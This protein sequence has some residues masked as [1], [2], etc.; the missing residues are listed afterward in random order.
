MKEFNVI[1]MGKMVDLVPNSKR[2]SPWFFFELVDIAASQQPVFALSMIK[3][4]SNN[5]K[6]KD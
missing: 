4:S 1:E 5:N 6:T 2:W 3:G